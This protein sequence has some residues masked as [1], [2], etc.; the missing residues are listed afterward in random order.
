MAFPTPPHPEERSQSASR[1]TQSAL[2]NTRGSIALHQ[3]RL[4]ERGTDERGEERVRLEWLR[5]E[6]GVELHADEPG[7]AGKLDDLGQL[8]VRRHAGKAQ[9]LVL[10]PSLVVDVDLVA[11]PVALADRDGAVDFAHLAAGGKNRLI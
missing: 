2:P 11:V 6:L 8:A 5:F 7:M 3:P 4:V 10:E 1:R 9:P